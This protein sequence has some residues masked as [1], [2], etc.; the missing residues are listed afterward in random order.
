ML[1]S[2]ASFFVSP[3]TSFRFN[4]SNR[5]WVKAWLFCLSTYKVSVRVKCIC[6]HAIVFSHLYVS[7]CSFDFLSFF[8]AFVAVL[9]NPPLWNHINIKMTLWCWWLNW[10]VKLLKATRR[11]RGSNED[12]GCWKAERGGLGIVSSVGMLPPAA[13]T[14]L[15]HSFPQSWNNR[16][17]HH[18][19]HR[20]LLLT[21]SAHSSLSLSSSRLTHINQ[22]SFIQ[23]SVSCSIFLSDF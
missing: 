12:L 15:Q 23:R 3:I 6:E 14:S 18:S 2:P 1:P 10:K 21:L 4:E 5:Y 19:P 7:S 8:S 22:E 13:V 11:F 20:H 9:Q 16:D 17:P